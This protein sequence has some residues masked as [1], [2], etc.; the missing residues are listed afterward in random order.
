M[1]TLLMAHVAAG[2][3]ARHATLGKDILFAL[4]RT[5]PRSTGSVTIR[6]FPAGMVLSYTDPFGNRVV[7]RDGGGDEDA[8]VALTLRSGILHSLVDVHSSIASLAVVTNTATENYALHITVTSTND[9]R[10]METF[11]LLVLLG[12]TTTSSSDGGDAGPVLVAPPAIELQGATGG[13]TAALEVDVQQGD[14]DNNNAFTSVMLQVA[15]DPVTGQFIGDVVLGDTVP[16]D[17]TFSAL[18]N[19]AFV[20]GSTASTAAERQASLDEL[21]TA[22]GLVFVSNDA[23]DG[24]FPQGITV[25]ATTVDTQGMLLCG[26]CVCNF[27]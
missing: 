25:T 13:S 6:G 12:N 17:I 18:G 5:L 2:L 24:D 20:I 26:V 22:G 4:L 1:P 27:G 3:S 21:L 11:P 7:V 15:Q 16:A 19:G 14:P 9:P 8:G 23:V 10:V